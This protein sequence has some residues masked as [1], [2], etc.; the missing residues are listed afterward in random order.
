M[1]AVGDG[2]PNYM[3]MVWYGMVGGHYV[4][5]SQISGVEMS[6]KNVNTVK[7]IT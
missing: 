4:T 2:V 3:V 6:F 1:T 5:F 7:L